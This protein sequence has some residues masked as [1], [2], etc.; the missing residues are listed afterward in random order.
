[1]RVAGFT[2]G[3]T[4][5]GTGYWSFT[6]WE[7]HG[8]WQQASTCQQV[9]RRERAGQKPA[10]RPGYAARKA[11]R[12][13]PRPPGARYGF[14]AGKRVKGRRRLVLPG[15]LASRVLASRVLAAAA[16][17]SPAAS[18][19]WGEATAL[20]DL[21]GPAPVVFGDGSFNG[22]AREPLAQRSGIW[23]EKPVR[24]R[25]EKMN[26]CLPTCLAL[27]CRAHLCLA[28]GKS[29]VVKERRPKL[30]PRRRLDLLGQPQTNA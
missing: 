14:D 27:D 21:L 1:M 12:T 29:S 17:D 18:A 3:L 7:A 22:V 8:T 5:W 16:T 9:R 25:V 19:F 15:P 20:H 13:Q 26:C 4:P 23:V 2:G 10:P 30:A 24:V 6:Q 11:A 28:Q